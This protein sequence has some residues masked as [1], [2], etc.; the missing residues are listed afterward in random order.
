MHVAFQAEIIQ[1]HE[2]EIVHNTG[3]GETPHR[4]YKRLKL[5]DG[6]LYDRLSVLDCHTSVN[7][8]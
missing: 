3:Q 6:H 8:Y 2:N 7:C 4:K 5:G 1:N